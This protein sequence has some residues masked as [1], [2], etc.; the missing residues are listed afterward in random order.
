MVI[1]L[2]LCEYTEYHYGIHF[3][4]F[5]LNAW[6]LWCVDFIS[7]KILKLLGIDQW[8]LTL[9]ACYN[10]LRLKNTDSQCPTYNQINQDIW[11]T[12]HGPGHLRSLNWEFLN[13]MIEGVDF[14]FSTSKGLSMGRVLNFVVVVVFKNPW[15]WNNFCLVFLESW[16]MPELHVLTRIILILGFCDEIHLLRMW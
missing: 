14:D 10:H 11:E 12:G 3:K 2:Q 8:F 4:A 13:W 9:A 6:I 7:I 5:M 16:R 15:A 1:V